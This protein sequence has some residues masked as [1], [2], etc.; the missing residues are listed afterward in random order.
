MMKNIGIFLVI[1]V[2]VGPWAVSDATGGW[3]DVLQKTIDSVSGGGQLDNAEIVNG[4]KEALEIGT[5]QATQ[6]AGQENGYLNNPKIK[7]PLPESMAKTET[8]VRAA[9]MGDQLDAF[10]LSM[11]RAAEQAAPEAQSIFWDAIKQMEF[12]DAK[13]ILNGGDNEATLYFQD[14]TT[15]QLTAVFKPLVH[16]S[17]ESVGVTQQYHTLQTG[18]E[19]IPF[20]SDWLVDLDDYVTS[21]ALEGLFVLVAEE[22]A[23]IRQDPAARV[24]DLLQKVFANP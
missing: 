20:L 4:L 12:D 14:K 9:G 13:R 21:Q 17:M 5:A 15:D 16:Q 10:V 11:N 24:T 7:I 22:E 6:L 2:L 23:K 1:V 8:L 19:A 18:A 3:T